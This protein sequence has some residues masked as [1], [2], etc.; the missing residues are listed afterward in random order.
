[1]I[2]TVNHE[3]ADVTTSCERCGGDRPHDAQRLVVSLHDRTDSSIQDDRVFLCAS[4][5]RRTHSQI[6]RC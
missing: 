2:K 5:W 6:R 3:T 4:C 1:M